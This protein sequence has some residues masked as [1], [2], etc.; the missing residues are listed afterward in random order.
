[1]A[2]SPSI[3]ACRVRLAD[4]NATQDADHI[5][6]LLDHYAEH[7]FGNSGPLPNNV[8]CNLIQ[9]LRAHPTTRVFVAESEEQCIGMALCFLGFSTFRARTLINV[10]DLIVHQ[11]YRGRGIGS[12]LLD[13]VTSTAQENGWCAVTLEV[14]ADNPA[15]RLYASKGFQ[16]LA[17]S[18]D[19]HTTLFGKLPLASHGR[20]A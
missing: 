18:L 13:A 3:A 10:H 15:K 6:R 20:E 11:A 16:G 17:D 4:L 14:R 2:D 9:G 5:L 12:A 19:E 7:P 1:M 8:R